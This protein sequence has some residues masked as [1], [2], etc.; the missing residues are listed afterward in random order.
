MG[1]INL[2]ENGQ[3]N[4][5]QIPFAF[6]EARLKYPNLPDRFVDSKID[7][8]DNLHKLN[9]LARA[10]ELYPDLINLNAIPSILN[11]LAHDN[12]DIAVDVVQLL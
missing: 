10:L 5:L 8:H 12:I 3:H 6:H 2:V 4:L 9:I 1:R 11:L 7:L